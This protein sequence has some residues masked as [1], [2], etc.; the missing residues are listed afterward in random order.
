MNQQTKQPAHTKGGRLNLNEA[1]EEELFS[2]GG[3]TRDT[4]HYFI[5]YR[6]E[7]GAFR[8]WE[9]F[10]NVRVPGA[11]KDHIRPLVTF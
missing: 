4:A 7:H 9:D 11:E 5:L 1:T 8:G 3:I 2:L 10:D 6:Q